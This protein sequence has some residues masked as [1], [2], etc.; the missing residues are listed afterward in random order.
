MELTVMRLGTVP[1]GEAL[2]LQVALHGE[3]VSG[4]RGDTL[5]LLE[6]PSVITLGKRAGDEDIVASRELLEKSGVEI[7]EINRGG[8]A[9]YH[10]PGQ[11][12]GYFIA[13]IRALGRD[14]HRFVSNIEQVI[15]DYLGDEHGIDAGRDAEHRGVWIG[16]EKIAAVGIAI[17]QG[18]SMHGFAFNITTDLSHFQWIIPC[19]IP[20]K[21]VTSLEKLLGRGEK[22]GTPGFDS[23]AES[24]ARRFAS[25]YGYD[26]TTFEKRALKEMPI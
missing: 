10:G 26:R 18:V 11:L 19:G 6:H 16:D 20:D 15:I 1:Y 22:P 4:Q 2:E 21:G 7:F 8:E 9:T 3:R 13:D 24:I 5:I 17:R 23:V 14:V 25:I 12:V